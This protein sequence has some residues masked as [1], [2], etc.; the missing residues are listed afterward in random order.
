MKLFCQSV[1]LFFFFVNFCRN[2]YVCFHGCKARPPAGFKVALFSI[3]MAYVVAFIYL[4][5][6]ALSEVFK[7]WNVQ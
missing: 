5:A 6:G 7:Y 4:K 3:V 1:L 2:L